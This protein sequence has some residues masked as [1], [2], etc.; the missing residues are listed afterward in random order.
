MRLICRPAHSLLL[1]SRAFSIL[2]GKRY[3]IIYLDAAN[4]ADYPFHHG[5]SAATQALL[6]A[7]SRGTYAKT[8]L[9]PMR[10]TNAQS[11]RPGQTIPLLHKLQAHAAPVPMRDKLIRHAAAVIHHARAN[12]PQYSYSVSAIAQVT[13]A[14]ARPYPLARGSV[15]TLS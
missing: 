5:K 2:G 7:Q 9:L 8:L 6:G 11:V 12:L 14:T 1:P 13:A 4:R 10:Q 15:R 3:A